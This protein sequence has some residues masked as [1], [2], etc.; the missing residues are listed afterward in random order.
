MPKCRVIINGKAYACGSC[1]TVFD[2]ANAKNLAIRCFN[3]HS[4]K[5]DALQSNFTPYNR[6]GDDNILEKDYRAGVDYPA[7]GKE[8][9]WRRVNRSNPDFYRIVM[10]KARLSAIRGELAELSRQKKQSELWNPRISPLQ[11]LAYAFHHGRWESVKQAAIAY[12]F[13]EAVQRKLNALNIP[14]ALQ[15][16]L[17]LKRELIKYLELEQDLTDEQFNAYIDEL[18]ECLS[19]ESTALDI[20]SY[21]ND[22]KTED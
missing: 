9:L 7:A 3:A 5:K 19:G 1:C 6:S 22:K 12:G 4:E 11:R 21:L 14:Q 17:H 10:N 13:S 18:R 15:D 2:G 8:H 16:A 20:E